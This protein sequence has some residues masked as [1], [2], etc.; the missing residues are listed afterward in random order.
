MELLRS[1]A[2]TGGAARIPQE[3]RSRTVAGKKKGKDKSKQAKEPMK[4]KG[5]KKK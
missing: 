2:R 1:V 3:R 5:P 4:N